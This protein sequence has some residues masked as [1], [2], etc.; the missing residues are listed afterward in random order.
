M[1]LNLT[2]AVQSIQPRAADDADAGFGHRKTPAKDCL[3][4]TA[5]I[6]PWRRDITLMVVT[7]ELKNH[8]AT[9]QQ[10]KSDKPK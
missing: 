7:A 8:R 2:E 5:V 1:F 9:E 10:R 6:A 3:Y 4:G